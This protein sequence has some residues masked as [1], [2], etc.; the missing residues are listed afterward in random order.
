VLRNAR[1][2]CGQ[3]F[4]VSLLLVRCASTAYVGFCDDK[5]LINV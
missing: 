2:I 3:P 5:S 4:V 1:V